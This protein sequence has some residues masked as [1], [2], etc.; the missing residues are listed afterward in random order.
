MSDQMADQLTIG[1]GSLFDGETVHG[2]ST[3]VVR[4]GVIREIRPEPGPGAEHIAG[5]AVAGAVGPAVRHDA[6]G[7]LTHLDLGPDTFLLP[8]LVDF[9]T[10]LCF[11]GSLD[12]VPALVDSTDDELLAVMREASAA[13]LR[14]GVTTVRDLG[15]RDFLSLRYREELAAAPTSAPEILVAGPPLTT[16]GGHCFFLG[17]VTEGIPALRAAVRD[18]AAR[19]CDVVKV[20]ASGGNITPNSAPHLS[21]FSPAELRAIVDEAHGLGLPVVAH[22]HGT[23]AVA[24]AVDAGVDELAHATFMTADG[25]ADAPA[26]LAEIARR[27]V[28]V[29]PTLSQLPATDLPLPAI[30]SRMEAIIKHFRAMVEAGVRIVYGSD[31]GV[32]PNKPHGVFPYTA[33]QAVAALGVSPLDALRAMTSAPADVCGVGARKGRIAVGSDADLLAVGGDP[34]ADLDRLHDVRAVFRAGVRVH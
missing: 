8:G 14:S 22:A 21:Q 30:A 19:G 2:P 10:H 3:I 24:A 25:I 6:G 11:D 13:M 12:P 15:D 31:S 27:G 9:H 18:R 7:R 32:A 23:E 16:A 26:L 28:V 20:M 1:A 34:L 4:G 29:D 17:G 33:A 5:D